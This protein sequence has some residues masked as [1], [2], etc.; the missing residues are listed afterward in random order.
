M[1]SSVARLLDIL[2]VIASGIGAYDLRFGVWHLTVPFSYGYLM[3]FAVLLTAFIFPEMGIYQSWRARGFMPAIGRMTSAW[4]LVFVGLLV[5]LTMGH[6]AQRYS[7]LFLLIW[8]FAGGA[9]WILER[10]LRRALLRSLRQRGYN[11]KRVVVVGCR[12]RAQDLIRRAMSGSEEGFDVVAV[13]CPIEQEGSVMEGLPVK[14]VAELPAFL[15][16]TV[17]AEIWIAVP[18]EQSAV[19]ANLLASL[20]HDMANIRYAPDTMGLLLLNHGVTE[21]L[22]VPMIDLLASPMVGRNRALKAFEDRVLAAVILLIIAPL[23]F[24]VACAVKL[25]SPGP[26]LFRQKRHGWDGREI[27]VLKFRTMVVHSEPEGVVTQATRHDAR[28]TPIGGFLR[29]TSLDELPQF[30][31]VLQGRMSIVGPRP[32]ALA[33]NDQ[34]RLLINGYMLRHKVKPGITGWAQVHDLRGATE[35]VDQMRARVA[36][37]LHY[38]EHWSLAF[39]FK[40]IMRTIAMVLGQRNAY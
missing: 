19:I 23:L 14:P 12:S 38:I 27:T 29:R 36:L 35:T 33:H 21:I 8:F 24:L 7:R 37:D 6:E 26:V 31:N 30:I 2:L 15:R 18:L 25:T 34:Y 5:F 20:P 22:Q 17:I 3:T 10:G 1:A 13:F 11:H 39:D 28:L 9:A 4:I 32:H 16:T 40:I